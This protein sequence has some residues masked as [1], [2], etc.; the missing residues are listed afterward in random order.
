MHFALVGPVRESWK[1]IRGGLQY[2]MSSVD[3][4]TGQVRQMVTIFGKPT[5]DDLW[6]MLY[7]AMAKPMPHSGQPGKP[8]YILFAHRWGDELTAPIIEYM[9]EQFGIFCELET[10][11][12][13]IKSA[14]LNG[15]DP[16]GYNF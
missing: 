5:R 6:Q 16:D 1:E 10:K 12:A 13:A 4:E 15:T 11:S 3:L 14:T 2:V 7:G 8:S 9:F